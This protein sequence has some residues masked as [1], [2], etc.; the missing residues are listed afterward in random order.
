MA[1][2]WASLD[3]LVVRIDLRGENP[4]AHVE[5]IALVAPERPSRTDGVALYV[6]GPGRATYDD[7]WR[8]T[9]DA[10]V[11]PWYWLDA[12]QGWAAV[13]TF[14]EGQARWSHTFGRDG[15]AGWREAFGEWGLGMLGDAMA[16]RGGMLAYA[17][18]E[19]HGQEVVAVAERGHGGVGV[20][21]GPPA[22]GL[23]LLVRPIHR[24][25]MWWRIR[26]GRWEGPLVGTFLLRPWDSALK[27]LLRYVLRPYFLALALATVLGLSGALVSL[28]ARRGSPP[29]PGPLPEG[30]GATALLAPIGG[31][32]VE[33][34]SPWPDPSPRAFPRLLAVGITICLALGVFGA[35][36][37]V[38]SAL[39]ERIPHVQDDVAYL[40]Q[41]R[42]FALGRLWVPTPPLPE[43]FVQ[44]FI[45]MKDG[46]WFAKYPPGHPALLALGVVAGAPWL[47]D[48]A[49]AA[50]AVAATAMLG[51]RTFGR[52]TGV[53]AAVL[54]A[55]S[56]FF[57]FLAG[58]FMSHT[59]GLLFIALFALLYVEADKGKRWAAALAGVA[60]GVDLLIRPWTALCLAAPFGLDLLGRLRRDRRETLELAL[61]MAAALLPFVAIYF[62]YNWYFTGDPLKTTMELWWPFDRLGFGADKGLAG[63]G[64]L[65]GLLNT[66]RNV[67]ELARDAFGWPSIAT[68]AFALVPV[69]A[70]RAGRWERLWLASSA[71][72]I[73]GYF[74]W[75]ADG[76][77]Y[78]P[79]FYH[80]A[81]P[82]IALLT[83]RGVALLG[84]IG[85]LPGRLATAGV[86]AT[87]LAVDVGFYLPSQLPQM[88]GYNYVSAAALA[89]VERADVHNAVVFV[90]PGPPAE[91]WNYG[92]VFSAN[93]PLLDGDVI[94]ARDLGAENGQLMALYPGRRFYRL[95][96][97]IVTEIGPDEQG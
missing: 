31:G 32:R 70:A 79:R 77:M 2:V 6:D 43:F 18:V 52:G 37:Y 71:A 10:I 5:G 42:V 91:W 86:L 85:R 82:F 66:L 69:A 87:L 22:D 94:F 54:L 72:L 1:L 39:L 88:R 38:A 75:W 45:V 8:Q 60:L 4:V 73:V 61:L 83:A 20:V 3:P 93:A 14:A 28:L 11:S 16:P 81:M 12:D 23:F 25:V 44:E 74:F 40:F 30:E 17:D 55:L 13:A 90:D 36:A 92:M 95:Y 53:L 58:S 21:I 7:P 29:H 41:A 34:V 33:R 48:P 97:T 84:D 67:S 78:G 19:L 9:L 51:A 15:L 46:M 57:L 50:L 56:P 63:H 89:A 35:T 59:N 65:N 47:V 49:A 27:D 24:D 68:F 96:R 80:E 76:V 26:E 64:P 62:A